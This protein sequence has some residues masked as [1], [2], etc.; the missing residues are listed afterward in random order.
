MSD[1]K[2]AWQMP[3]GLMRLAGAGVELAAGVG[4]AC[5]LGWWIDR[6]FE[7]SPWALLICA[8]LGVVGSL[9]NLVRQS[10]R[11]IART[12]AAAKGKDRRPPDQAS[13]S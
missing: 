5:L 8:V 11:D 1:P 2:S 4:G 6:H 13:P 3:P 12:P 7:T 9:Y 10:V